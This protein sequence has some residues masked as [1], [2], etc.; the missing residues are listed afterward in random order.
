MQQARDM[1]RRFLRKYE[2]VLQTQFIAKNH[3]IL[4]EN[5]VIKQKVA[6]EDLRYRFK[7]SMKAQKR[8]KTE[9]EQEVQER[10]EKMSV[11]SLQLKARRVNHREMLY[12]VE[13]DLMDFV[14]TRKELQASER[15]LESYRNSFD[16]IM[17]S[18]VGRVIRERTGEATSVTS[19]ASPEAV[20]SVLRA[21]KAYAYQE[22]SLGLVFQQLTYEV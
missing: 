9:T 15:R 14:N 17:R 12:Q 21:F 4:A 10:I 3:F 11:R 16:T 18:G 7:D 8:V 1:H 20:S 19:Y 13:H 5:D 6:N 22:S 2:T